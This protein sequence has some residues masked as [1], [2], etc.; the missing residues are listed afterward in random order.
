M[1][2]PADIHACTT[3]A[4]I[5]AAIVVKP[6][7]PCGRQIL[8]AVGLIDVHFHAVYAKWT[9][10]LWTLPITVVVPVGVRMIWADGV[11]IVVHTPLRTAIVYVELN[12]STQE[13][14]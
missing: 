2:L 5:T 11:E 1:E 9:A 3:A 14:E 12:V 6:G 10:G 7:V 4:L 13:V 8:G